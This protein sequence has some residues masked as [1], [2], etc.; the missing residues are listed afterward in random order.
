MNSEEF[1]ILKPSIY[2]LQESLLT[3]WILSESFETIY[4]VNLQPRIVPRRFFFWIFFF[5]SASKKKIFPFFVQS[6]GVERVFYMPGSQLIE[7]A[8]HI[9]QWVKFKNNRVCLLKDFYMLHKNSYIISF[10]LTL[11]NGNLKCYTL[12]LKIVYFLKK[13]WEIWSYKLHKPQLKIL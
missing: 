1:Y 7:L 9:D 11:D 4:F 3:D 5:F 12:I 8:T 13:Y 10:F 2:S 6:N